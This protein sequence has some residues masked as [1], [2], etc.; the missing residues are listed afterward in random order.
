VI[1]T[2]GRLQQA[3]HADGDDRQPSCGAFLLLLSAL[4]VFRLHD[5]LIAGIY[6]NNFTARM[7]TLADSNQC[8]RVREK[9]FEISSTVLPAPSP[10]HNISE[11]KSHL[12]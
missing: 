5:T 2:A 6:N 3:V 9:T 11:M 8:I 4:E 12:K 10:Y 1:V 7:Y